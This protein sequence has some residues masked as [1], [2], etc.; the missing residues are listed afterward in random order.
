MGRVAKYK[1]VKAGFRDSRDKD[2]DRAP[3]R[4]KL[5]KESY[6]QRAFKEM[7]EMASKKKRDKKKNK[8]RKRIDEIES[9]EDTSEGKDKAQQSV[10]SHSKKSK[11]ISETKKRPGETNGQYNRRMREL[12]NQIIIR[13][14]KA[15]QKTTAKKKNYLNAKKEKKKRRKEMTIQRKR[16]G[17][18]DGFKKVDVIPFGATND[19]VPS[20]S[21]VPKAVAQKG[22]KKKL[23]K[24][25]SPAMQRERGACH[26]S[27]SRNVGKE[28]ARRIVM[29]QLVRF[30]C[31]LLVVHVLEKSRK[32]IANIYFYYHIIT[33]PH[34]KKY[35]IHI[36]FVLDHYM[37]DLVFGRE[38]PT[39][40]AALSVRSDLVILSPEYLFAKY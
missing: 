6:S 28:E 19:T 39:R 31:C 2:C 16:A 1:K 15:M 20:L 21:V 13:N 3:S 11:A 26:G 36:R 29:N 24:P 17:S 10:P 32:N 23:P 30:S 4:K 35:I 27:I 22:Q 38:R 34:K 14:T 18:D 12:N 25:L 40:R 8:K 33:T 7:M 37:S 9:N 5:R